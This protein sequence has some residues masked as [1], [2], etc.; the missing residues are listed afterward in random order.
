MAD[1]KNLET[2]LKRLE[3]A[4][5][6]LSESQGRYQ[7]LSEQRVMLGKSIE[8]KWGCTPDELRQL[9]VDKQNELTKLSERINADLDQIGLKLG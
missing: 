5:R 1:A 9:I 3:D 2:A 8:E 6:L 4:R 7:T